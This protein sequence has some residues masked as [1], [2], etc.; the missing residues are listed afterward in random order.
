MALSSSGE[1]GAKPAPLAVSGHSPASRSE[2]SASKVGRKP[3]R[4]C[5][6]QPRGQV[7]N[8]E[9]A[10]MSRV[11]CVERFL[12][13]TILETI[14][15]PKRQTRG[16]VETLGSQRIAEGILP[17]FSHRHPRRHTQ[18]IIKD[19]STLAVRRGA[20]RCADGICE[21]GCPALTE[22]SNA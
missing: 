22:R 2:F 3:F 18:V 5:A 8:V 6:F 16:D 12:P 21:Q 14:S 15:G 20:W 17:S 13:S 1:R 7:Y 4:I 11:D 9:E 10:G 19:T